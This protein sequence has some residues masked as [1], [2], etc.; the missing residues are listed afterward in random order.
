MAPHHVAASY[1][2]HA[3]VFS[4]GVYRRLERLRDG[5]AVPA[6]LSNARFGAVPVPATD[7]DSQLQY[8]R[9]FR[10]ADYFDDSDLDSVLVLLGADHGHGKRRRTERLAV[11]IMFV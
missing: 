11:K 9:V 5:I 1:A 7:A 6:E 4:D 10:G 2:D 8:A 3:D